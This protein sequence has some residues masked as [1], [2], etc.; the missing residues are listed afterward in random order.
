MISSKAR[1]CAFFRNVSIGAAILYALFL[2]AC[3]INLTT[4][5]ETNL[6]ISGT[7]PFFKEINLYYAGQRQALPNQMLQAYSSAFDT[8]AYPADK[9]HATANILVTI[10]K[11]KK[12]QGRAWYIGSLIIPFWPAQPVN[13]DW[14]YRLIAKVSCNETIIHNFEF[15][16]SSHV[17]AFWFGALRSDL[18]NQASREMHH[19][20]IERLKFETS[21]NRQTDLNSASDY[22]Q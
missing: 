15:I 21:V 19:K 3:S 18:V 8:S 10:K 6:E 13:E 22:I 7:K 1:H 17:Q 16:E 4:L 12:K 2:Q 20:F 11:P 5:G 14:T 9:C